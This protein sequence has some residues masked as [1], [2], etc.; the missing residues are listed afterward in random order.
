MDFKPTLGQ[1]SIFRWRLAEMDQ[2]WPRPL[3]RKGG[4]PGCV[5]RTEEDGR[6]GSAVQ[7]GKIRETAVAD[8]HRLRLVG[9]K[10]AVGSGTRGGEDHTWVVTLRVADRAG[11]R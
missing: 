1:I 5:A 11:L 7:R 3:C 2:H 4:A 8:R 6:E 9:N 10:S